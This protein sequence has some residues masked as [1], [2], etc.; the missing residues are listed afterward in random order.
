MLKMRTNMSKF[1]LLPLS[2][3]LGTKEIKVGQHYLYSSIH[4]VI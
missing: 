1:P 4:V 3:I 2:P